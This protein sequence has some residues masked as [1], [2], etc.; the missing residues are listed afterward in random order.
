M[1][2][3]IL[4]LK[5]IGISQPMNGATSHLGLKAIDFGWNQKYYKE[6]TELLAPFDGTVVWKK[7]GSNTIA[8]QSNEPVEYADGTVDYMTVIT[9]HDNNAPSVGKTFKQGEV[10]SHSG[11]AGGVPLHCHLEV[12]KGKFQS[13]TAIKN[14]SKDGRYSSYIFPNTYIPYNALFVRNDEIYTTN[15][16]NNPYIWKKVGDETV[17]NLIKITKD[18]DYDYKW[19]IDGNRYGDKYDITTQNGFGDLELESNGW[20]RVLK[21]NASLFYSWNDN[22]VVKHFACGLEKSRGVN[23]QELEMDCV[24]DYNSCM[25]IACVGGELYFASQDWII[26]NKLNESYG[27]VTGLGLILGGKAR[28][29]MHK[30]FEGQWNQLAGRTI[31]GEDKDGNFLSFSIEGDD[32]KG[33]L[34]GAQ[35]QSKCLELGFYNAIMLDGGSSVFREYE[36]KY[37]ISTGR[38]VKNALILYRKKKTVQEEPKA[39]EEQKTDEDLTDYKE[40]Y[41]QMKTKANQLEEDLKSMTNNY[42]SLEND[43][44]KL[45][46]ADEELSKQYKQ[47]SDEIESLKS[48]NEN[49]S[50]KIK[51]IKDLVA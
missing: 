47:V 44:L 30:G 45:S 11:K 2:K 39:D 21:T 8:F 22:W 42:N 37:D 10:Y 33:G 25:A 29:D 50:E 1:Q 5:Y 31:I 40:L 28:N 6:S 41:N 48:Q 43:Y 3:A 34:T 14:T 13:Y 32:N 4:P 20:E 18:K 9:A 23:N 36:G 7:G 51:K 46:M 26:K 24:K 16:A 38:K 19:S 17:G 12:Q 15:K 35:A 49:L 27:A